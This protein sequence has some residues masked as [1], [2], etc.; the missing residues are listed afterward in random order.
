[1]RD[2]AEPDGARGIR[3]GAAPAVLISGFVRARHFVRD[4]RC[5]GRVVNAWLIDGVH[6][7]HMF[8]P[9]QPL[10]I[11]P[12]ERGRFDVSAGAGS[13]KDR[14]QAGL[15]VGE[16]NG[17]KAVKWLTSACLGAFLAVAAQSHAFGWG[18]VRGPYGGAAYRGPMGGAAVRTPS[19]AAAYR[20]PAGNTAVRGPYGNTAVHT[21]GYYGG[22]AVHTGGYY[23][24]TTVYRG[25]YYGAP[26][27]GAGVAAGVA[28][29]AAVGTAAAASAYPYYYPPPYYCAPPY[30]CPPP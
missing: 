21:G 17:S 22:T 11:E 30:T 16:S 15:R 13:G 26:A 8:S 10:G 18:A 7:L 4:D 1:M 6:P 28:V 9:Q 2:D 24:G 5:G 19:G 29:G 27:V 12:S 14:A 3:R 23:G 25:G 20:G